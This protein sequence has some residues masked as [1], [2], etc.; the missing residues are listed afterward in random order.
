MIRILVVED[1]QALRRTVC[2][3]LLQRG[4]EATGCAGAQ[5]AYEAMYGGMYDLIVSDVMM[6]GIDGFEFAATVRDIN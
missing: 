6:P 4:Y 2:M 1:D 3:V 5:E